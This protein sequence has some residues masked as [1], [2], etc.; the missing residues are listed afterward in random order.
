M[1]VKPPSPP[2][3]PQPPPPGN[4]QILHPESRFHLKVHNGWAWVM[5]SPQDRKSGQGL[6]DDGEWLLQLKDGTWRCIK[7]PGNSEEFYERGQGFEDFVKKLRTALPEVPA[8]IF[9]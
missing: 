7:Y 4:K 5:A 3:K 6:A 9:P 8:D 1:C 2:W